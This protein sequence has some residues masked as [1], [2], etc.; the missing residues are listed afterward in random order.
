MLPPSPDRFPP[1][2]LEINPI[3]R[4][5]LD[6]VFDEDINTSKLTSQSL[7]ITS[8]NG[9]TLKIRTLTRGKTTNIVSLFTERIKPEEYYL[10]GAV[11][12]KFGNIR[13]IINKKFK[14]NTIIDTFPPIISSIAPK[15]GATKI[16]KKI[17]FDFGFSKPMDTL[18]VINYLVYPLDKNKIRWEWGSDWQNLTFSYPD[19]LSPHT[20]VYFILQPTLKDLE[21][22]RLENYGYTFFYTDSVLPPMLTSGNLSYENKPYK[23]GIVIFASDLTKRVAVSDMSGKFSVRL[24]SALYNVT[25]IADT[26]YDNMVD[27]FAEQKTFSF[28]DTTTIKFNLIPILESK[29]IDSYLR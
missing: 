1:N 16:Y 17:Y 21:N 22:N 7:T 9:E 24:D 6:L 12:D 3:N 13:N 23:K 28:K 20:T 8:R 11:E 15:I 14:G 27:L 26:N 2:L 29:E 5:K 19:S 4:I 10:S 25:A 18:S